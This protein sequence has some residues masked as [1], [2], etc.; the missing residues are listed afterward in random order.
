MRPP[1]YPADTLAKGWRLALNIQ[2][3]KASEAWLVARSGAIRGQI[4]LMW[5]EAWQ[6][7]PCGT[8]PNDKKYIATLIDVPLSAFLKNEAALMHGWWIAD[9][10][11]LY[12]EVLTEQALAM[13]HKRNQ[14]YRKHRD[15]VM[16]KHGNACVYCN[17]VDREITLDHVVSRHSGGSDHPDN[18]VPACRPCNSSKGAKSILEWIR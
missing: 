10:G 18:L 15:A 8:L 4:L 9:D 3:V 12:H 13:R 16:L 14:E 2:A 5:S 6:Q 11:R 1:P 7:A 17:A